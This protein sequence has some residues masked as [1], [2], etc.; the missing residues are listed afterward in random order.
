MAAIKPIANVVTRALKE[1]NGFNFHA[2]IPAT[3]LRRIGQEADDNVG[4]ALRELSTRY[5]NAITTLRAEVGDQ[6]I[7]ASAVMRNGDDVIG[8]LSVK[9]NDGIIDALRNMLNRKKTNCPITALNEVS[10]PKFVKVPGEKLVD[11]KAYKNIE[12]TLKS[13]EE[14]KK[15]HPDIF[16]EIKKYAKG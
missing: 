14:L 9:G 4:L 10:S 1:L 8:E 7:N 2:E 3:T 15:Q 12:K 5:P 6:F 13:Y 16:E 11:T